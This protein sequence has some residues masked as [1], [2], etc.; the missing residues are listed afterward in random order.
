MN[1]PNIRWKRLA[2]V[3]LAASAAW[4]GQAADLCPT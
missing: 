4:L 3:A 2:L 1:K